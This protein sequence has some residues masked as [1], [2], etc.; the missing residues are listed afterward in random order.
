MLSEYC[1]LFACDGLEAMRILHEHDG[2]NLLI[3]DLNMPH[4]NGFQVLESLKE[5][6][7]FRKLRTIILT[8]YDELDNEIKGLKLGAVDYIRKPIH[9]DSLRARIDVH[10]ALL[11]AE[12]TLEQQ[13]DDQKLSFEVIFEQAPIG[14]AISQSNDPR[15]SDVDIVKINSMY[16][17]ITGRTKEELRKLGWAK[18]THPDDLEEDLNNFRKLQAGEIQKYSM[19]K[20]LMKPDGSIVWLY[21]TVAALSRKGGDVFNYICLIQDITARKRLEIERKYM[22]EHNKWTGL[23]NREYLEALL[24]HDASKKKSIR[25]AL[26]GINLS[27]VQLLTLNYGYVY[28]Q[29]LIKKAA[30]ALS[31]HCTD[32]RL[33]FQTHENRFVFY[34]VDYKDKKELTDFSDAIAKSLTPLFVSERVGG[35]IGI[36]EIEQY[37]TEIDADLLLRRLLIASEKSMSIYGMDFESCFYNTDIEFSVNRERDIKDALSEIAAGYS[38]HEF[39]VHYQPILDLR[40]NNICGFE[41]LARLRTNK[42]GLVSPLEFI[43]IAEKTKLIIPI[44]EKVLVNACH[45]LN[46]LKSNGYGEIGVSVNVSAIQLFSPNFTKRFFELISEMKVNPRN[47]GIEIT[48]SVFTSDYDY[49]NKIID[50]LS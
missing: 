15:H 38:D 4:M 16:E 39:F 13:L 23:Y 26:V 34:I 3:L 48:E 45:F 20:R 42:L 41:A 24:A 28:T 29:G 27:A 31:R 43:P 5:H 49:I 50:E 9:M 36:L 8:N 33:L 1:I 19:E 37:D 22:S 7:R 32:N 2:I 21:M 47:I 25:K 10:V 40:T 44:G 17:Q 30:E 6:E 11:R 35:G 18:I 12:H 14:I 46:R